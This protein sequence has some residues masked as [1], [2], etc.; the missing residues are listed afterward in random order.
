VS[1][2]IRRLVGKARDAEKKKAKESERAAG[3]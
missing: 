1:G 2:D 3:E